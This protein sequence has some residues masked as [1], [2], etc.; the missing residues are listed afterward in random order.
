MIVPPPHPATL[1]PEELLKQ[2][3]SQRSRTS[4]PGGQHRNKVETAIRLVH[5]PTGVHGA[6]GE[7]RQQQA[8]RRMALRR[9]RMNLALEVRTEVAMPYAPSSLW[10]GRCRGD[11]I[12][13][14]PEH[15]DYPALLAEA[16]DVL[17]VQAMDIK[18]AA[19]VLGVST[20]QLIKLIK[21][22]PHALAS[23]NRQRKEL[24]V[25]ALH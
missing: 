22:E 13:V 1:E 17:A 9:L 2:C 24:G 14:N 10:Q 18:A 3:R 16:L 12:A 11:R 23:V 8:N 4:G 15:A 20:S 5:D 7:R 21:L 25:H 6:A 19:A